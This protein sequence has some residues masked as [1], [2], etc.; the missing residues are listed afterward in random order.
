MEKAGKTYRFIT[1][2]LGSVRM[3]VDTSNGNIVQRID[4]DEFG[5]ILNDTNPSFQPFGFA[6]GIYD[7]S[8]GLTR[9][10]ARDYDAYTGRWTAKDPIGFAGE[11]TNLYGYVVNDPVNFLDPEGNLRVP[12]TDININAGEGYG[13]DALNYWA[14]KAAQADN[15]FSGGLYNTMGGLAALWTPCTSYKTAS[16]LGIGLG[17]GRYL[18]RPYYQYYP[19]GN[20][21]YSSPYLTR[22]WGW[23]APHQVGKEAASKLSLPAHNPGTAVRQIKVNPFQYLKGPS[24]VAPAN[25]GS[26]GGIEYLK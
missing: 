11:D 8:T 17:V 12:F 24:R 13:Q 1:D 26:G 23:K 18:G 14:N 25:G 4:Y 22:G 7:S 15:P 9:F 3:V 21:G 19:A 16:V 5:R 10:G 2:H 6:G 20:P